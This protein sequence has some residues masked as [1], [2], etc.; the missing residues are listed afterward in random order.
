MMSTH[1]WSAYAMV[2]FAW[3]ID[4][5]HL[6]GVVQFRGVT[7]TFSRWQTAS[8]SAFIKSPEGEGALMFKQVLHQKVLSR[9]DLFA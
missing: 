2:Q 3:R 4:E 8:A 6:V 5:L 1:E 7:A 9:L